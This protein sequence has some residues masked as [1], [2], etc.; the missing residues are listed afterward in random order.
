MYGAVSELAKVKK[1]QD[2][3]EFTVTN[4]KKNY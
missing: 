3:Y 4:V 2:E 1:L